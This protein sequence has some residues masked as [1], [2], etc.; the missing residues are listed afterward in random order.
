MSNASCTVLPSITEGFGLTAA[1]SISLGVPTLYHQVGG[2]H[3]LQ[4]SS[5]A[6]PITLTTGERA[7]LYRLMSEL[8][9]TYSWAVWTRHEKSLRPLIDKCIEAV[10][11]T[12]YR[13]KVAFAPASNDRLASQPTVEDQWGNKL[14][15]R[16]EMGARI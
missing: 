4:P 14:L 15:R 13:G 9:A 8:S 5:N 12:T 1:E 7:H 2:H 16:I 6:L 3:G 10:R 11:S